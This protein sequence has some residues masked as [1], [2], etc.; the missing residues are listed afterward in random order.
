MKDLNQRGLF[1]PPPATTPVPDALHSA[2]PPAPP[3]AAPEWSDAT[4]EAARAYLR[5]RWRE[6]TE[7]P[8]CGQTVKLYRRTINRAMAEALLA[9]VATDD[10][11][12]HGAALPEEYAT[13]DGSYHVER[14]LKATPWVPA[15]AR[16]DV[17]K[18]RY[19]GLIAPSPDGRRGW[20]R[21]SAR[22]RMFAEARLHVP[23]YVHLFNDTAYTV[24]GDEAATPLGI[25]ALLDGPGEYD[26]ARE[27][28]ALYG[29][30]RPGGRQV[31]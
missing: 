16:G 8:C 18:L 14:L 4:V 11:R 13:A 9:L 31:A 10:A 6:G 27:Q 30:W 3:P 23:R 28:A 29:P 15:Q 1:D 24:A 25:V 22:G 2:A 21:V 20:W 26:A 12:R 7:C 17:I 5:E 19:W